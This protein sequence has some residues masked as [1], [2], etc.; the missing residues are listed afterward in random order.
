MITLHSIISEQ[1]TTATFISSLHRL[2]HVDG[3][4]FLY[5]SLAPEYT[6]AQFIRTSAVE[7]T[8]N[9]RRIATAYGLS[10][11]AR[12]F[13]AERTLIPPEHVPIIWSMINDQFRLKILD[14]DLRTIPRHIPGLR[15]A[16]DRGYLT[17]YPQRDSH[18]GYFYPPIEDESTKHQLLEHMK[19]LAEDLSS[20]DVFR[21]TRVHLYAQFVEKS[22][23]TLEHAYWM[24]SKEQLIEPRPSRA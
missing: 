2:L 15:D 22:G 10:H 19:V 1:N 9:T 18:Q 14:C 5:E 3:H 12:G 16:L 24:P 13:R 20:N 21:E 7:F 4:Y 11:I 17:L 23:A 6:L 8:N